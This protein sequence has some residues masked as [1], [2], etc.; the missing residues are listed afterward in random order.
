MARRSKKSKPTLPTPDPRPPGL[1]LPQGITLQNVEGALQITWRWFSPKYIFFAIFALIWN[2]F[3]FT[4]FTG[5]GLP[6][7]AAF[8]CPHV[9]VGLGLAYYA[10]SGFINSTVITVT[11][12]L[13][14]VQHGPIPSWGNKQI[15]PLLIKQLYT[16]Q[17][18]HRSKNT[19]S[20]TYEVHMQAWHS[21]AQ[22][23][24]TGLET[25]E[26]ALFIEQELERHLGI[27]NKAVPGELSDPNIKSGQINWDNWQKLADRNG[28]TFSSGK[29]LEAFRVFGSY[30]GYDTELTTFRHKQGAQ[31]QTR[32]AMRRKLDK[33]Q[34]P[35]DSSFQNFSPVTLA[36]I[37]KILNPASLN[38]ANEATIS[39]LEHGQ[40]IVYEQADIKTDVEHL[41]AL[42]DSL[43]TIAHV[44]PQIVAL[45]GEAVP[46][47]RQIAADD[48]RLS[49]DIAARLIEEIAPTTL[50]IGSQMPQLVCRR[51][52][53]HPTLQ[54]ANMS[55]LSTVSYYGC[56]V[57]HQ[58]KSFFAVGK[59]VAV[60][61]NQ[62]SA[63]PIQQEDG[64]RANWLARR[65]LFD[66]D[67]VE[68]IRASD[69]EAERFAV[70]VGNDTDPLRQPK[71]KD[72]PCLIDAESGLSENSVRI[73]QHIFGKIDIHRSLG[74]TS[75]ETMA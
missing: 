6:I 43:A 7:L 64:L 74:T 58:S 29:L 59:V 2:G 22:A 61:D 31:P 75:N 3:L 45:G 5:D 54:E 62:M 32:L 33:G 60:L 41:Q 52:L 14:T 49:K 66:F 30:S 40:L 71:Y 55:W 57:C 18:I 47:L 50:H 4:F 25:T 9:W 37:P 13:L 21:K 23:L 46:I 56:R 70:Q 34:P 63:E 67:A 17:K 36:G 42:L 39:S 19:T 44:Y 15:D 72:M 12:T 69:E 27:E 35:V 68:I 26:Q 28:L 8:I 53:V 73:L 20:Y 48:R 1:Q 65:A 51:C 16:K 38:F 11:P 10:L 24:I